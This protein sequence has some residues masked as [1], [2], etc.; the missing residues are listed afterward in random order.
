MRALVY[1]LSLA[2]VVLGV[3]LIGLAVYIHLTVDPLVGLFL[4]AGAGGGGLMLVLYAGEWW[5]QAR[6]DRKRSQ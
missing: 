5:W 4:V 2:G 1:W 6:R 3:V